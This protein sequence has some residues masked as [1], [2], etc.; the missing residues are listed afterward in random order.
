MVL[1]GDVGELEVER[2]RAQNLAWRSSVERR[3]GLAES[4]REEALAL[5]G[6]PRQRPDPLLLGEQLLTL[7]L[8]E[9]QAK[10]IAEEA[11]VATERSVCAHRCGESREAVR[12]RLRRPCPSATREG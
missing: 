3:D 12:I 8:D 5:S 11:D 7:L 4:A 1:L 6:L 9:N 10:E 2:E